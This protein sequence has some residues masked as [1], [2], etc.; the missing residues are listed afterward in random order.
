MDLQLPAMPSYSKTLTV[1]VRLIP[2]FLL[3]YFMQIVVPMCLKFCTA[4]RRA[5]ESI[6]VVVLKRSILF[7]DCHTF[8]SI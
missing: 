6:N 8:L 1:S 7:A 4:Q 5:P 3:L 2:L